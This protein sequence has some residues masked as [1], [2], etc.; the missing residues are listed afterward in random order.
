MYEC[1]VCVCGYREDGRI[2][3]L[4]LRSLHELFSFTGRFFFTFDRSL[5]TTFCTTSYKYRTSSPLM[6]P[7]KSIEKHVI[8]P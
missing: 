8:C 6:N 4:L 3:F 7:E 1:R 5:Q 2:S